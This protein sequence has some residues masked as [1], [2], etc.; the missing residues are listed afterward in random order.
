MNDNITVKTTTGMTTIARES[1]IG[2]TIEN[3]TTMNIHLESGTIFTAID[4]DVNLLAP[5]I[6]GNE[7]SPW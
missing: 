6:I 1:I 7:D 2:F 5:L 3:P 4:M